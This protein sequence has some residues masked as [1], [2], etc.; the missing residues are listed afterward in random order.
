MSTPPPSTNGPSTN[1]PSTNGPLTPEK[2]K[3]METN[4]LKAKAKQIEAERR[5]ALPTTATAGDG[6]TKR[7][8]A[9]VALSDDI[10]PAK[11]FASGYIEYDFSK[12]KDTKAG[13][14]LDPSTDLPAQ[15]GQTLHDHLLDQQRRK[16]LHAPPPPLNPSLAPKCSECKTS[17]DLDPQF[18]QVFH[19]LVCHTCKETHPEKYSLLTKTEAKSDYLL[20]DPELRDTQLLPHLLRPNPH[21]P[22]WSSMQLYLRSQVEAFAIQKWGSLEKMDGEFERREGMKKEARDKK[23]EGR[24]RELRK[25]T[26]VETWKKREGRGGGGA[27]GGRH[28]HEWGGEAEKDGVVVRRCVGCGMETEEIV[29]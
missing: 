4:R 25:K 5:A 23:F 15:G 9:A 22:M 19:V 12:I 11:K 1:G 20:T 14:M 10:Q 28:E 27:G 17:T 8:G 21:K 3:Q 7:K 29:F 24:L 6:S 26:R 13:F 18:E 2:V 16:T